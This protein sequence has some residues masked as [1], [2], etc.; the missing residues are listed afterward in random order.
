MSERR[1]DS[2]DE[3]ASGYREIHN[4]NI[5]LSG[6]NSFYFA[7]MKVKLL[8]EFESDRPLKVLDL[9]CGDGLTES[10]FNS[11]FP[12][13]QVTGID[14][15]E[16]SIAE[17]ERRNLKANFQVYNGLDIPFE[18][19]TFDIVFVAGVFHHVAFEFHQQLIRS[20]NRVLATNGKLYLFEH[21]PLN[22]LTRYLVNTCEFDRDAKLLSSTYTSS[23]MKAS[24]FTV[25]HK[26]FIIFFPRNRFFRIFLPLEKFFRRLPF[27]GQYFLVGE[28]AGT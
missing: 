13:W 19:E 9:G 20:I 24:G 21:N 27:G 26:R 16:K 11:Y 1:F 25:R 22:P 15:S 4:K 14:I 5:R 7:E 10:Y 28:K 18:G 8:A 17:A 3:Y 12:S 2:F 6:A 23:L